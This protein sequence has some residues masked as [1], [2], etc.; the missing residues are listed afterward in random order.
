V[1]PADDKAN[2]RLIVSRIVVETLKGLDMAYPRPDPA[3]RKELLALRRLL[4]K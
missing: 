4:A 1:V 2:A 3:R